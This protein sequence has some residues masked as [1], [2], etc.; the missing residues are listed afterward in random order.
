MKR[1]KKTQSHGLVKKLQQQRDQLS[2]LLNGG[3]LTVK[4]V[5]K[6]GLGEGV[7]IEQRDY[8]RRLFRDFTE[9][10]TAKILLRLALDVLCGITLVKR[11]P[12]SRRLALSTTDFIQTMMDGATEFDKPDTRSDST[13]TNLKPGEDSGA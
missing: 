5:T 12:R 11:E 6:S 10:Q 7:L 4:Q 3:T 13:H 8:H 1:N 2:H 9:G